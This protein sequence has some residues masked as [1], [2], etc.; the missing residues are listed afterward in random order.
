VKLALPFLVLFAI[1]C[2]RKMAQPPVVITPPIEK[3]PPEN[4]PPSQADSRVRCIVSFQK[5]ACFGQ[6]PVF[7]AKIFSDGRAEYF[8]EKYAPHIGHFSAKLTKNWLAD[9]M[10]TAQNYAFFD[11]ESYY[12]T[13]HQKIPDLPM[14]V[15]F[16][17][18][19]GKKWRIEDHFD[20][21][22]A[23]RDFEKK[24]E[25]QIEALDWSPAR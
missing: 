15:T 8:G 19:E 2:H 7:E 24:V 17:E 22:L 18:F 6:C 10:K 1:G 25:T 20:A 5:T 23:L 9:F 21:P 13:S 4:Q 12:P 11:L 14:T 3:L 16:V